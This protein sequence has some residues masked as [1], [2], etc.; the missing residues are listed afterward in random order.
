MIWPSFA[1]LDYG[2][3]TTSTI[4]HEES[5]CRAKVSDDDFSSSHCT[6]VHEAKE[7]DLPDKVLPG[8]LFLYYEKS[9]KG[10]NALE[11]ELCEIE[12]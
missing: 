8:F 3:P 7:Q 9:E 6:D 2:K 5:C 12:Q 4:G 11:D 1:C 10:Q